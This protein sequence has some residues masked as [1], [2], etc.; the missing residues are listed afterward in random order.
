MPLY[1]PARLASAGT[2]TQTYSTAD[3]THAVAAQTA[4]ATTGATNVTPFGYTTRA[5]ANDIVA[6]LN[7]ARLDILELKQ[8]A[9]SIA[10]IVQATGAAG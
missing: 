3:A 2:L 4:V 1:L 6:Q 7:N 9:N 5:Q 10:D 8:F